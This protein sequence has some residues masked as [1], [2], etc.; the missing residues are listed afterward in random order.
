MKWRKLDPTA[1]VINGKFRYHS[2]Y[3]SGK[4]Q[5]GVFETRNDYDKEIILENG[6]QAYP[7]YLVAYTITEELKDE[8]VKERQHDVHLK[9][10]KPNKKKSVYEVNDVVEVLYT[11]HEKKNVWGTAVIKARK[12]KSFQ[13]SEYEYQFKYEINYPNKSKNYNWSQLCEDTYWNP[14]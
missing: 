14:S 5:P 13:N 2:R 8:E 4:D 12:W 11:N 9:Q 10:S 1:K 7:E 3:M 6:D